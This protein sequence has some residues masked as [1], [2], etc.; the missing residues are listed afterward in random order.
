MG[1]I[2][3]FFNVVALFLIATYNTH[4]YFLQLSTDGL[5]HRPKRLSFIQV[6]VCQYP[7]RLPDRPHLVIMWS[8]RC[9]E[10][11]SNLGLPFIAFSTSVERIDKK[12]FSYQRSLPATE[13]G[14]FGYQHLQQRSHSFPPDFSAS[15][16]KGAAY[17]LRP[18]QQSFRKIEGIG[19]LLPTTSHVNFN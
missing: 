7:A 13:T 9:A 8:S 1:K 11:S 12:L 5:S 4:L 15:V 14:F 19:T 6:G 2:P 10:S 3:R 16:A 18:Q 17:P